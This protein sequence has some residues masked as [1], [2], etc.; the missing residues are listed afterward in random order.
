MKISKDIS[1]ILPTYDEA[2]NVVIL[3][4]ALEKFLRNQKIDFEIIVVDDNSPDGTAD[5]CKKLNKKYKNINVIVKEKKEG[6]GA[7]LRVGYSAGKKSILLSMDSDLSF[8]FED[9]ARFLQE[10]DSKELVV[11]CRYIENGYYEKKQ[12]TTAIKATVSR[13]GNKFIKLISGINLD[14]YT[15]NF[16]AIKK[17]VYDQLQLCENNN[18]FLMEMIIKTAYSGFKVGQIPVHFKE[19][20]Y[21]KSKLNL[22]LEAPKF[23]LKT[24]KYVLKAR[25]GL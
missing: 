21:G 11:A 4:P 10:M 1:I 3:I 14:D 5:I 8:Q 24:V 12:L 15:T 7:A 25:L 9:I 17:E 16:R 18:A 23:F 20:I 19:R 22:A 13:F 6:I 2:E